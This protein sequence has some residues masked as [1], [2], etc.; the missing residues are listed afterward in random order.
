LQSN[1]VNDAIKINILAHYSKN[2]NDVTS[3]TPLDATKLNLE[4][5]MASL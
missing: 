4:H 2:L 5:E 3:F 1:G